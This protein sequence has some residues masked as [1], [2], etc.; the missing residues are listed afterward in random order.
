VNISSTVYGD[1]SNNL[2]EFALIDTHLCIGSLQIE[3]LGNFD[4]LLDKTN[5]NLFTNNNYP[6]NYRASRLFWSMKNARQKTV[7]HLHIEID[8]IYHNDLSNHQVIK[9]PMTNEQIHNEQLYDT[10]RKYFTKFQKQIDDHINYI[11][12]FCQ[13]TTINKKGTIQNNKQKKT[14]SNKKRHLF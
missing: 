2:V 13:K 5:D 12:E 14:T 11:E 6:N 10:C 8:Q 7:Y 9:H 4:Y 3:S 1:L